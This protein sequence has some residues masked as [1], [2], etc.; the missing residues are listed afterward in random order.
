MAS[1]E[2]TLPTWDLEQYYLN[3]RGHGQIQRLKFIASKS[4]P[5][6]IDALLH[7]VRLIKEKTFNVSMYRE[8]VEQLQRLNPS[9]PESTID[10]T[11]ADHALRS[12]RLTA[13]KLEAELKLYK[14]NLIKESIR[15]S[16]IKYVQGQQR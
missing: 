1:F 9:L 15:V 14:T 3:Y 2:Q 11:W 6:Q 7:A 12:S 10:R 4:P 13:E 8:V 5:L 16:P